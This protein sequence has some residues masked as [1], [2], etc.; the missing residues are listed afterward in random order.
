LKLAI[1]GQSEK[2]QKIKKEIG[3]SD[4]QRQEV[5]AYCQLAILITNVI[6]SKISYLKGLLDH[7]LNE[8]TRSEIKPATSSPVLIF[9]IYDNKAGVNGEKEE[10]EKEEK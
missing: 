6:N 1:K 3:D 7:Y 9:V 8:Q 2:L 5:L 10:G 4:K